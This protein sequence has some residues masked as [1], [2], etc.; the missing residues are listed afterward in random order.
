MLYNRVN[1]ILRPIS[2]NASLP[3]DGPGP[4]LRGRNLNPLD[5]DT[6][7]VPQPENRRGSARRRRRLT[8]AGAGWRWE[9]HMRLSLDLG[10]HLKVAPTDDAPEDEGLPALPGAQEPFWDEL[11]QRANRTNKALWLPEA[12]ARAFL[13]PAMLQVSAPRLIPKGGSHWSYFEPD[14]ATRVTHWDPV[15]IVCETPGATIYYEVDEGWEDWE[16]QRE[17]EMLP[18]RFRWKRYTGPFCL[19]G[20]SNRR[21]EGPQRVRVQC[22]AYKE[23][24]LPSAELSRE[25]HTVVDN[26]AKSFLLL[27]REYAGKTQ[28]VACTSPSPPPVPAPRPPLPGGHVSPRL[29]CVRRA[30]SA[31][32]RASSAW[33]RGEA[34][35]RGH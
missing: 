3:D 10:L 26:R 25:Y 28:Q 9:S 12:R 13:R 15:S 19:P 8:R 20:P 35:P 11:V 29:P 17:D 1:H 14:G 23:G 31:A 16:W 22:V 33:R 5:A 2:F 18:H 34:R 7:A 21:Y 30:S 24:M 27:E 4:A 6:L 32:V